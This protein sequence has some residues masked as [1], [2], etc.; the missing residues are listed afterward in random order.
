MGLL[1][2][3]VCVCILSRG[4]GSLLSQISFHIISCASF[5]MH[6]VEVYEFLS[7]GTSPVHR[8]YGFNLSFVAYPLFLDVSSSGF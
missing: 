5:L 3:C 8:E 4:V 2:V 6:K 1:V 7:T